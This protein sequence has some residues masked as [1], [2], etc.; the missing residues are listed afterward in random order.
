MAKTANLNVR[1]DPDL[2]SH[3]HGILEAS[4]LTPTVA[5][6]V[7]YRQIARKRGIP[8]EI[9]APE[10]TDVYYLQDNEEALALA[11]KIMKDNNSLMEA[12]AK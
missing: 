3:V 7:Y 5:I 4:G 12:L 6:E 11:R 2:K 8:F 9:I 10:T 1:I